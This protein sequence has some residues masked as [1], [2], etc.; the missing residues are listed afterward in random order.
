[1]ISHT[2]QMALQ[3]SAGKLDSSQVGRFCVY[4]VTSVVVLGGWLATWTLI[5]GLGLTIALVLPIAVI[6]FSMIPSTVR[7]GQ[8]VRPAAV[9]Y[10]R[11][12]VR[13]L[14]T[15]NHVEMIDPAW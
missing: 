3:D 11:G 13:R 8:A 1:M 15:H 12:M 2:P 9:T 10:N 6:A 5:L 7:R 14:R 4:A